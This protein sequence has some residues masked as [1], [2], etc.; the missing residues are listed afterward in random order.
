L[1]GLR[2]TL[3]LAFDGKVLRSGCFSTGEFGSVQQTD[4]YK[5]YSG[6]C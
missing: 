2:V 3:L 6:L 4:H 5:S 1:L